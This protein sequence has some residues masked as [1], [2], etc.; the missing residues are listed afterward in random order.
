MARSRLASE[1]R[2]N[3]FRRPV[4]DGDPRHREHARIRCNRASHGRAGAEES[5]LLSKPFRIRVE[6]SVRIGEGCGTPAGKLS[7]AFDAFAYLGSLLRVV[8]ACEPR[9]GERMRAELDQAARRVPHLL[10]THWARPVPGC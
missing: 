7:D 1:V 6:I 10:R 3:L 8:K 5:C 2:A 9:V 4:P